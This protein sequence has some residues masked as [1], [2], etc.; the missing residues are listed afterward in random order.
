MGRP[1][2]FFVL[3]LFS[4]LLL[5]PAARAVLITEGCLPENI[6]PGQFLIRTQASPDS[7]PL[8]LKG[9]AP[10]ARLIGAVEI[11]I[12]AENLYQKSS[13]KLISTHVAQL[14]NESALEGLKNNPQVLSIE[15]D[16]MVHIYA[17][18]NDPL[19]E[20]NIGFKSINAPGAWD[21]RHET[22][23][24]VAVPDTGID[25]SHPDLAANIWTNLA[26]LNGRP[27]VDDDGNGF[28]DDINGWAFPENSS[29]VTP[30][31]YEES[32]HGTHVAGI[33]GAVGN[34][35]IG[36]SGV[37]WAVKIMPIRVFKKSSNE[38][39]LSDL[40]SSIYYAVNNGAQIINCS[41]G[42]E[43]A[44]SQAE[45]DAFSLAEQKGVLIVAAAGNTAKD[46]KNFSPASIS[47]VISIGS[48]NSRFELSTFSNFGKTV[49]IL[50]PGGDIPTSFGVGLD[51]KIFS[52]LPG[53]SYGELRGTSVAA[54]FVAGGAALVKALLPKLSAAG[55]RALL[56]DGGDIINLR[57]DQVS[58][59]Y[60]RLNLLKLFSL[61]KQVATQNPNCVE[62]CAQAG[63]AELASLSQTGIAKFGGGGCSTTSL[64]TNA[65]AAG[66]AWDLA[67]LLSGFVGFIARSLN[68]YINLPK[69]KKYIKKINPLSLRGFIK[70][71]S[72]NF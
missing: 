24:I 60:S 16:C 17:L 7:A 23:V 9:H 40:I 68:K 28:V 1:I 46:A 65:K 62:N 33:I 49:K 3:Y 41:W 53:N 22:G 63:L 36:T 67:F 51:E 21:I 71:I 57:T 54:P 20:A 52:T 32:G 42:S 8:S 26:E 45:L 14:E 56:F 29:D 44:P 61:T 11:N 59:S 70:W 55:L 48:M 5:S 15:P 25:I 64:Q 72:K 30:G 18:P 37:A 66:S 34:N 2:F 58:H 47:T 69:D 27:G 35:G 10:R 31:N 50:A 43:Q 4:T 6:I 12:P 39:A 13:K 19:A 38:A